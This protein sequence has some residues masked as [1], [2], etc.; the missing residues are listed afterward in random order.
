MGLFIPIL[1]QIIRKKY[2]LFYYFLYLFASCF[3]KYLQIITFGRPAI[4][5]VFENII[6]PNLPVQL[7]LFSKILNELFN[8]VNTALGNSIGWHVHLTLDV[9]EKSKLFGY[10]LPFYSNKTTPYPFAKIENPKHF[11]GLWLVCSIDE[12]RNNPDFEYEFSIVLAN[13]INQLE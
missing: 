2:R 6:H 8:G 9:S 12:L 11:L 1:S 4:D 10:N 7:L 5:G 13:L 3:H